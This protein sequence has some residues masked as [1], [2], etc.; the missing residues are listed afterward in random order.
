M[1]KETELFSWSVRLILK[2]VIVSAKC[3][4]ACRSRFLTEVFVP[5]ADE[6]LK[7]VALLRQKVVEL[8]GLI[9]IFRSQFEAKSERRHLTIKERL[10]VMWH[11]EFF[12]I[13]RRHAKKYYGISCS[14][15]YRWLQRINHTTTSTSPANKTSEEIVK[16]VWEIAQ[17]NSGWGKLRIAHQLGLLNILIAASTIRNVLRRPRP[18]KTTAKPEPAG[19]A[20]KSKRKVD[21]K[22][23]YANHVWSTDLTTVKL[24]GIRTIH[25]LAAIDHFSRKVVAV[26]PLKRPDADSACAALKCAF[27]EFGSPSLMITDE[28]SIFTSKIFGK[29]LG[30]WKVKHREGPIGESGSI[31]VTERL[32]LTLK[33]EW[34]RRVVFI[35]GFKHLK[36]LCSE[37]VLWH[38]AFRPHQT[39]GGARP[40]D[41]YSQSKLN[42]ATWTSPSRIS[43]TVPTNIESIHF[44][45]TRTTA[46]RLKHAA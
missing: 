7:E 28:G 42:K 46:W 12:G 31:A 29:L 4:A 8:E 43:K 18:R 21:I 37:F 9:S 13:P 26:V 17:K 23:L 14:T 25:V 19:T 41:I 40:D 39:L 5:H 34:L 15:I 10:L 3:A 16:L 32:I 27:E 24:W 45:D 33:S 1:K 6:L 38:G 30:D 36:C 44:A 11:M 35:R 2:S 20:S 22:A